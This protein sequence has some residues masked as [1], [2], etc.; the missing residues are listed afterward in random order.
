FF[1]V[2][3]TSAHKDEA[4]K[5]VNYFLTDIEANKVL[6]AE[7]G[8]P[9]V[10]AVRTALYNMV[11]P[12]NKQVFEYIDL[13]AD[14]NASAID[15]ADPVGAGEVLKLFRNSVQEVLYGTTTSKEAAAKFMKQ[16]NMVL[17]KNKNLK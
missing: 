15:P 8:I 14:K 9:I 11:D 7:R 16:A 5:F 1:S 3:K 10:P 6:L 12:V 4:I 2:S 17:A 13:V